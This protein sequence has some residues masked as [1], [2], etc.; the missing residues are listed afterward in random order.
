MNQQ[1]EH[2]QYQQQRG[3]NREHRHHRM[4]QQFFETPPPIAYGYVDTSW[5]AHMVMMQHLEAHQRYVL[6]CNY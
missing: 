3:G 1:E 2:Q 4:Q 5:E 6:H